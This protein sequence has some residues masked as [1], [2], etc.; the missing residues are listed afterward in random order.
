MKGHKLGC[1]LQK[2][3]HKFLLKQCASFFFFFNLWFY[4]CN[5][6]IIK[7]LNALKCWMTSLQMG[8]GMRTRVDFSNRSQKA[9]SQ[10]SRKRWIQC[11]NGALNI[12]PLN[13]FCPNL[14]IC[15]SVQKLSKKI[16]HEPEFIDFFGNLWGHHGSDKDGPG[17][18]FCPMCGCFW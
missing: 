13:H 5:N 10:R 18:C 7:W 17:S 12:F 6:W 9:F 1:L 11:V 2:C 4:S 15:L 8:G 16:P 14:L 3:I